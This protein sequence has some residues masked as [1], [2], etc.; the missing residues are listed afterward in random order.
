MNILIP[1]TVLALA[2]TGTAAAQE[3]Q[4]DA[5]F[6]ET[7]L[8]AGFEPNP[9]TVNVRTGGF[10]DAASEIGGACAG[11]IAI[12]PDFR[13]T[14]SGDGEAL[15]VST[16]SVFPTTLVVHGPDGRWHCPDDDNG[17]GD[18]LIRFDAPQA[19]DYAIWVATLDGDTQ[20]TLTITEDRPDA[21]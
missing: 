11:M 10:L 13:V 17:G 21:N 6:G 12:A 7:T 3:A 19:G 14:Y 4:F 16:R 2:L 20:A 15:A 8:E 9:V 18:N 5:T 1:T